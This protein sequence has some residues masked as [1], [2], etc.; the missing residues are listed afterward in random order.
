[1][2]VQVAPNLNCHTLDWTDYYLGTCYLLVSLQQQP[3]CPFFT[4]A[5]AAGTVHFLKSGRSELPLGSAKVHANSLT[6][7]SLTS[8]KCL[9]L[10]P[11]NLNVD[12]H[13]FYT[14]R[15]TVLCNLVSLLLFLLLT[16]ITICC[17]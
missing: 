3:S 8:L 13:C 5:T 4:D 12:V 16:T 15:A 17:T 11:L 7:I 1:M 14:A 10:S 6:E 9:P 2:C